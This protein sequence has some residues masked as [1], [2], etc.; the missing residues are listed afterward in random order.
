MYQK[1]TAWLLVGT[2][3]AAPLAA[4]AEVAVGA[5][6][7]TLGPGISATVGLSKQFNARFGYNHYSYDESRT[8]S[9]ID[10]NA[11]LELDTL[12]AML[13]WHPLGGGFRLSA[14]LMNN[15]NQIT[16]TAKLN[17]NYQIGDTTYTPDQVGRLDA[18]IGFDDIAPYFGIGWGNA[19]SQDGRLSFAIE[20]GVLLQGEP[21][22]QLSHSGGT[23]TP[24]E[25]DELNRN[26]AEEERD[27]EDDFDDYYPVLS[28]GL[29]YRF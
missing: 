22:V 11:E 26:L 28:I 7:G 18:D 27:I 12:A 9:E 14:G 13:D 25:Q 15:G 5:N 19:I 23:L 2:L 3:L 1:H 20:A 4:R 29:A 6:I 8:E 21:D 16:G 10:Y 24:A 17:Q